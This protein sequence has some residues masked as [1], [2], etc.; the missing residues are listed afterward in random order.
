M[1]EIVVYFKLI[2]K[3]IP[4]GT[5]KSHRSHIS[6]DVLSTEIRIR[7]NNIKVNLIEIGDED[8]AW[9]DLAQDRV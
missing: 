9:A 2:F 3:H 7:E 6:I 1:K 8:V 5:G 4:G